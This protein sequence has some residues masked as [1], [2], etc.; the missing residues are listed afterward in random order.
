LAGGGRGAEEVHVV[1][2]AMCQKNTMFFMRL[3]EPT[4][5]QLAY[6]A[7]SQ[8]KPVIVGALLTLTLDRNFDYLIDMINKVNKML[9]LEAG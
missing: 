2:Q 8:P 1:V 7:G 3:L 9:R 5:L 4:Q 6:S